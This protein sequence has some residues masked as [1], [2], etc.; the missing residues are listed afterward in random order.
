MEQLEREPLA[1]DFKACKSNWIKFSKKELSLLPHNTTHYQWKDYC[2]AV[3]RHIRQIG[4]IDF[5]DYMPSVCCGE[6]LS[7]V[8]APG[9]CSS[10]IFL[11]MD[12]RFALKILKKSEMKVWLNMLPNYYKHIKKY[13]SSLFVKLYGL[14]VVR[15]AGGVKVYFA[16]MS[17]LLQSDLSINK[18]YDLKGTPKGRTLNRG[19][20][21]EQQAILKDQ[22][23]EF[24]FYLDPL[25]RARLLA[26]IKYDCEFLESEGIMNYS[27]LLGIHMQAPQTSL[28]ESSFEG[29]IISCTTEETQENDEE[30]CDPENT[31]DSELTLADLCSTPGRSNLQFGAK[32]PARSV[33][34]PVN[35][36]GSMSFE[37]T[38]KAEGC[39]EV[40]LYF[41]IVDCVKHYSMIKRFEH[42]YKS[43]QYDS[44]SIPAVNPK[45]YSTRFQEFCSNIFR[46][47]KEL[48]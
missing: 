29:S 47:E 34:I 23:L 37:R 28:E 39:Q 45:A 43:I 11:S 26:Q 46:D 22:D 40:F 31:D 8:F 15:P 17:N 32:M 13:E 41:G 14:H 24:Y 48:E 36:M 42:A 6:T 18:C 10:P 33:Q 1:S 4:N 16:V 9:K 25:V 30:T 19:V 20:G 21:H 2:P 44:I 35:E 27:L 12:D 5:A 7:A 38:L 3:F